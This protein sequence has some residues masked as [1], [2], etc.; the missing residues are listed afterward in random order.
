MLT[1]SQARAHRLRGFCRPADARKP[2]LRKHDFFW[3]KH[4]NLKKSYR[5]FFL[6]TEVYKNLEKKI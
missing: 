1:D 4:E 2:A 3:I 5:L 6:P